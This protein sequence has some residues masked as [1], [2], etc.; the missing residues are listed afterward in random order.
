MTEPLQISW[1]NKTKLGLLGRNAPDQSVH[2]NKDNAKVAPRS[3]APADEI[4]PP[5]RYMFTTS[6]KRIELL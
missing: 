6:P 4:D 5:G 3:G 1:Q 2:E